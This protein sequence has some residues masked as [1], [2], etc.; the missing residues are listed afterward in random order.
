M[1]L[2]HFFN[3]LAEAS[4]PEPEAEKAPADLLIKLLEIFKK[5]V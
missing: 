4:K 3:D 1:V 2:Q 5:S